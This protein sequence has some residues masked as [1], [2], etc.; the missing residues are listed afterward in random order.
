MRK[1]RVLVIDDAV[2]I[3]H[4]LSEVINKDDEL[5][6]SGV[7]ANGKIALRKLPQV[8]PDIITLDIEMPELDGIETL[9]EIRKTDKKTPVIMLSSLTK[10]GA[11]KTFEA[12]AAGATDYLPKPVDNG[13]FTQTMEQLAQQLIPRIKAHFPNKITPP[14]THRRF[15]KTNRENSSKAKQTASP[16]IICI[17]CSTGGP[18]ALESI[19]S[20]LQNP[21]PVPTVIV[22]HMPPVFT[23]TLAERLNKKSA[24]TIYE[25]SHNQLLKPGC[26]YIA[27]GGKHME[28]RKDASGTY[29]HLN[30]KSPE[31]SCRPS[32]DPLFRSTAEIYGAHVLGIILTGMGQDGLR[33]CEA[34][35]DA[36][37]TIIVQD[38]E[39]CIVWGMPRAVSESGL[40]NSIVPLDKIPQEILDRL[41]CPGVTPYKRTLQSNE[42]LH[43]KL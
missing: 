18:N 8:V 13:D 33:G 19:I 11:E 36:G 12:L 9:K 16:E 25:A 40:A 26:T 42:N 27:P 32:V 23:K 22:Q 5:E 1:I 31:N 2:V 43:S 37:G 20:K 30:E 7:A 4:L 17:G 34:I 24:N 14:S 6:V 28:L 38:Q 29:I 3:R 10:S 39:S 35:S 15:K 41:N 21:L